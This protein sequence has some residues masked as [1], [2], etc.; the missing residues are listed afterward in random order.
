MNIDTVNAVE[1]ELIKPI[2]T[3]LPRT[4]IV[5]LYRKKQISR[6]E[7]LGLMFYKNES[8]FDINYYLNNFNDVSITMKKNN[9]HETSRERVLLIITHLNDLNKR[10]TINILR[11]QTAWLKDDCN[12]ILTSMVENGSI[13]KTVEVV[14]GKD[15]TYYD[16]PTKPKLL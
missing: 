9:T 16:Y 5:N 4:T 3:R 6:D 14:N 10:L 1:Y 2:K 11:Q 8:L 13:T 7:Y 12:S 15:V